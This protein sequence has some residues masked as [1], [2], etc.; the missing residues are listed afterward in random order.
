MNI[1]HA[2]NPFHLIFCFELLGDTFLLSQLLHQP[3][4]HFCCLVIYNIIEGIFV[5]QFVGGDAFV[6][7]NLGFCICAVISL[8]PFVLKNSVLKFRKPKFSAAM[9]KRIVACGMPN[10]LNNIAGRLFSLV[11][12]VLLIRMGGTL[13][14]S[15]FSL[16]M[17]CSDL[18]Q[19]ALYGLCSFGPWV[20][21]VCG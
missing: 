2:L 1:V 21:T 20:L 19:P 4:K 5:G 14:V 11:M 12:N 3:I 16:L 18:V 10:F 17:Y 7:M 13:A 15:A 6:A 8:I 9:L